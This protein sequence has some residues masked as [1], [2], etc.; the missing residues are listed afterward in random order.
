[1]ET[2]RPTLLKGDKF[3]WL[4][5]VLQFRAHKIERSEFPLGG[6]I[7]RVTTSDGK[8]REIYCGN[9]M[10]ECLKAIN[11]DEKVT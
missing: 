3:N 11:K 5:N 9:V 10:N 7:Y 4:N 8:N 2:K 1:M 6:W